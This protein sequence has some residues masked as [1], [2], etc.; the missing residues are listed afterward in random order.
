M[1]KETLE[2]TCDW[3]M[4]GAVYPETLAEN[5][6]LVSPFHQEQ[7]RAEFLKN[8]QNKAYYKERILSNIKKFDPI[9]KLVSEAGD[10]FAIVINYHTKNGHNVWETVLCKVNAK[11]LLT[12]I[13]SIYDLEQTL[14]AHGNL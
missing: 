1:I 4:N 8:F 2:K 5:F 14:K 13:R 12:E 7:N 9:V 6:R 11:G 10:Y 3:L